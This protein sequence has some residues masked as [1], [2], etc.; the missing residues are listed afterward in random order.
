MQQLREFGKLVCTGKPFTA[1][2]FSNR[3]RRNACIFSQMLN[4]NV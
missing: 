4:R 1:F 2:P 3:L